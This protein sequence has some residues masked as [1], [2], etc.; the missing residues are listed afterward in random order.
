MNRWYH[1]RDF[2][3][4]SRSVDIDSKPK[5]YSYLSLGV[6]TAMILAM[7]TGLVP[8]LVAVGIAAMILLISGCITPHDARNSVDW[9]V[10]LI[11]ASAFGIARAMDN[12]GVAFFLANQIIQ[13]I[14]GL[15]VVGMLAAIYFITSF[16]TEIIT[17]NAAAALVFPIALSITQQ[18]GL[19]PRPFL[20]GIALAASASFAT[21]I[22]YQTNLMVYGPGGYKF[23]DFMKI[24]I[25]MNVFIGIIAITALSIFYF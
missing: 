21:P 2:Y 3:L 9:K 7:A 22:G 4:V 12:S 19:D 15:G 25:P 16:Y 17:N 6:L 10:L 20:I 18:A 24:G 5:A 13:V 1:T 14:G 23:K 8:I 11:I